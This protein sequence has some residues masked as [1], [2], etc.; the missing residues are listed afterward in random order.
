MLQLLMVVRRA[1]ALAFRGH[2]EVVLENMALRQQLMAMKRANGR[3][4]L[5]ARD[6]LF[7]IALRRIW[8]RWRTAL[9]LVRPETVVGWH[10]TAP[11]AMDPALNTSSERPSARR[12]GD[13]R[14]HP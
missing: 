11:P 14:P 3:P 7:W 13:P 12:A 5:Q 8:V 6:R 9:V 1:L 10:R 4:R 2:R